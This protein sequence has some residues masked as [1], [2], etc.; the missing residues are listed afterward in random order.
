MLILPV[1]QR[2][3]T[4]KLSCYFVKRTK[5]SVMIQAMQDK[6]SLKGRHIVIAGPV[7]IIG[8]YLLVTMPY[9]LWMNTL[10]KKKLS[11][12]NHVLNSC[13]VYDLSLI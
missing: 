1:G 4:I 9:L 3:D 8:A 5:C 12:K 13:V 6:L 7:S 10:K 2:R 11:T